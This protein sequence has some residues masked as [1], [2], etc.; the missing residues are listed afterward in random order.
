MSKQAWPTRHAWSLKTSIVLSEWASQ[1]GG[2]Q[3][4]AVL[5]RP[6]MPGGVMF[7]LIGDESYTRALPREEARLK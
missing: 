1:V 4:P 3:W 6:I 2:R 5:V 7:E